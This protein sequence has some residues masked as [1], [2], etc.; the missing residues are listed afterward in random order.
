MDA[1][2]LSQEE[3]RKTREEALRL[4]SRGYGVCEI[5]ESLGIHRS[6]VGRWLN[7]YHLYG[8]VTLEKKPKGRKPGANQ[9]LSRADTFHLIAVCFT[10]SPKQVGLVG[11]VWDRQTIAQ[12]IFAN[13]RV[14]V[15]PDYVARL[16]RNWSFPKQ[17]PPQFLQSATY[18]DLLTGETMSLESAIRENGN[19]RLRQLAYISAVP[20]E[21]SILDRL[22]LGL[23]KHRSKGPKE[24]ELNQPRVLLCAH[25]P[26]G[27]LRFRCHPAP[28]TATIRQSFLRALASNHEGPI[29]AVFRDRFQLTPSGRKWLSRN[30]ERVRGI[31]PMLKILRH[32][33]SASRAPPLS[34][35][36]SPALPGLQ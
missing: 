17:Q 9:T 15:K 3:L 1:R 25:D 19:Y 2:K 36:W 6:T 31:A 24:N 4:Q 35:A 33:V 30:S 21:D 20:V 29:L 16:L 12:F 7:D 5:A 27:R 22:I 14:D 34:P 13:W 26:H 18:Q 32:Q 10:K 28:A 11:S 23:E 8:G